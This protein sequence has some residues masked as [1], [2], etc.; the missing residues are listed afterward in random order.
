MNDDMPEKQT[1]EEPNPTE[2]WL[3]KKAELD[4]KKKKEV[5]E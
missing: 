1:Y 3:K 4:L 5:E 2:S